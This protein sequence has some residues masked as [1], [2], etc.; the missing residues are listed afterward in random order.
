MMG[1]TISFCF[2]SGKR[3]NSGKQANTCRPLCLIRILDSIIKIFLEK[4][5]TDSQCQSAN[6]T[7]KQILRYIGFDRPFGKV[8]R[9]NDVEIADGGFLGNTGLF[10]FLQ[11]EGEHVGVNFGNTGE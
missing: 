5:Q 10:V 3:G 7:Q 2:I 9:I 6:Q 4:G 11:E 8:G 1:Q